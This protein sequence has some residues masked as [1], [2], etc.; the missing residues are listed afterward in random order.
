MTTFWYYWQTGR[1]LRNSFV[2]YFSPTLT[3][4]DPPIPYLPLETY[5]ASGALYK[6]AMFWIDEIDE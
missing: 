5:Q 4:K 6:W 3:F 2:G 1:M